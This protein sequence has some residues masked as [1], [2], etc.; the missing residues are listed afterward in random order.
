[1]NVGNAILIK[2]H[3][4]KI[5]VNC[6][7]MATAALHL[8]CSYEITLSNWPKSHPDF[9]IACKISKERMG[10]S[11]GKC[12]YETIPNSYGMNW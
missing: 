2:T 3:D 6:I 9:G 4:L 5:R 10:I 11:C 8:M 1:M 7:H 12:E